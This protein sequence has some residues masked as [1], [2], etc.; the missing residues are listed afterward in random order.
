[1]SGV[2]ECVVCVWGCVSE[3]VGVCEREG[4]RV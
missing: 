4:E 3:W 1:M 2:R